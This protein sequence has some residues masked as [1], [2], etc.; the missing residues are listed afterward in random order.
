MQYYVCALP[1]SF[2]VSNKLISYY[3][4]ILISTN[5]IH[6]DDE[7]ERGRER[8]REGRK[9]G[10]REGGRKGERERERDKER[11]TVYRELETERETDRDREREEGRERDR[12]RE[13]ETYTGRGG[14]RGDNPHP[15]SSPKHLIR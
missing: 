11:E 12:E 7:R 15:P 13:R 3:T 2:F 4:S 5:W 8:E 6:I 9:G 1:R 10:E 14:R